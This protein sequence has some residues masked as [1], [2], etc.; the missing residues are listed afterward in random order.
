[1]NACRIGKAMLE[2]SELLKG[3]LQTKPSSAFPVALFGTQDLLVTDTTTNT[4]YLT[5]L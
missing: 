3:P 2:S 4:Y 1:M 5:V